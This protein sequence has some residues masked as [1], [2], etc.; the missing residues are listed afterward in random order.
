MNPWSIPNKSTRDKTVKQTR[1]KARI[2]LLHSDTLWSCELIG[3][4]QGHF[5]GFARCSKHVANLSPCPTTAVEKFNAN[6]FQIYTVY[7][8]D[9]FQFFQTFWKVELEVPTAHAQLTL[10][11]PITQTYVHACASPAFALNK[12]RWSSLPGDVLCS[13]SR[14]FPVHLPLSW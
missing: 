7:L 11:I 1:N 14:Y 4:L 13:Q 12:S 6:T 10:T 9:F 3:A 2:Q 8:L 5:A